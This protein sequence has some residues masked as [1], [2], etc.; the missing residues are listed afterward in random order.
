MSITRAQQPRAPSVIQETSSPS[1][2][3]FWLDTQD[4]RRRLRGAARHL[5]A[6]HPEI[7]EVWLFGS[8]ARGEA[9]PGSDAD[10]QIVLTSSDLPFPERS[11]CYQPEFC[12][13]GADVLAHTRAELQRMRSEGN[14]F[15][16]QIEGER[17][18]LWQRH[19]AGSL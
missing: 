11:V 1:V 17:V 13:I 14:P 5:G 12:G 4:V 10:I 3:V 2:S 16:R 6:V 19:A 7:E 15:L 9:V 8:L 18:A